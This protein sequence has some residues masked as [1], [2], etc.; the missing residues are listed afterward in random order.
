MLDTSVV[1][2]GDHHLMMTVIVNA[3]IGLIVRETTLGLLVVIGIDQTLP[4]MM[5]ASVKGRPHLVGIVI[6]TTVGEESRKSSESTKSRE[7]MISSENMSTVIECRHLETTAM[8][9]PMVTPMVTA[10][11]TAIVMATP[12][13]PPHPTLTPDLPLDQHPL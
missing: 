1:N 10:T 7:N 3:L 8:A 12:L 13:D 11:G 4:A 9:T 6:A 5:S 2:I